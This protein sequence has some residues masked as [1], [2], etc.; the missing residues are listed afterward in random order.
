MK[1]VLVGC[2]SWM[3]R[4]LGSKGYHHWP[5]EWSALS[6]REEFQSADES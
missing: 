5:T 2:G 1:S 4:Y 6:S 3:F